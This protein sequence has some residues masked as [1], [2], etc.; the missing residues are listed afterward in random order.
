MSQEEMEKQVNFVSSFLKREKKLG[1][2][3]ETSE[4]FIPFN[5]YG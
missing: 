3:D 4:N 1:P 5:H 2:V